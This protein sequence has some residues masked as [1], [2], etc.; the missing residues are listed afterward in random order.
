MK[1]LV[2]SGHEVLAWLEGRKTVIRRLMIP[3]PDKYVLHQ[4]GDSSTSESRRR[5]S[6]FC[7][8]LCD[9]PEIKDVV[10]IQQT[11]RPGE[12]VYIKEVWQDFCPPWDGAW[13]GC[14]SK[15]MIAKTHK[16]AYLATGTGIDHKGQKN[17][18]PEKWKSSLVMPEWAS[19]SHALIV[20][21]RPE[22]VREITE[23]DALKEGV[24]SASKEAAPGTGN[25]IPNAVNE[26]IRIWESLHPGSWE[27]NEWVWR[28][29]LK[30]EGRKRRPRERIT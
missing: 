3:P 19:R 24:I 20:S 18:L 23:V 28:I 12:T 29:E 1:G 22:R 30:K 16:V 11:Y 7:W 27:R 15:E 13:C 14:G 26:F 17:V 6:H 2:F 10:W 4:Q 5:N 25:Y 9:G 8:Q 21:I